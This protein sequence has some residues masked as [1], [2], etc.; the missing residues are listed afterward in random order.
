MSW[1]SQLG[2][3]TACGVKGMGMMLEFSCFFLEQ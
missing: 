3:N 1:D 2:L